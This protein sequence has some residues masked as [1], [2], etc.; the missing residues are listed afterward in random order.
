MQINLDE[1][2]AC[3]DDGTVDQ[4]AMLLAL[5]PVIAKFASGRDGSNAALEKVIDQ[6]FNKETDGKIIPTM[7][8][9]TKVL[10]LQGASLDGM[11]AMK[12]EVQT[13]VKSCP[14]FE[15]GP[16]RGGGV[17][18]L[19]LKD[20]ENAREHGLAEPDAVETLPPAEPCE[21]QG[22]TEVELAEVAAAE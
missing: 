8:L 9:V 21:T 11:G 13:F 6:V 22:E 20:A 2:V 19:S 5:V 12:K 17:K 16:G 4:D 15:A 1:Y 18:R 14:R 7:V 10:T 3:N